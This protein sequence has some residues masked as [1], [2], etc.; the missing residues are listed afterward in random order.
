MISQINPDSL[1]NLFR[2]E[3]FELLE[4]TIDNMSPSLAEYY[5]ESLINRNEDIYF[6]KK[7]IE[8]SISIGNYN[9]YIDYNKNIYIEEL[10][11][12]IDETTQSFW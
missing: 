8:T 2:I 12:M 9:I 4:N 10:T 1:Y 11:K 3:N 5:L 6:N 7:D